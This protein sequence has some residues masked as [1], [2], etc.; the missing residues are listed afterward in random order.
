MAGE[1]TPEK[2]PHGRKCVYPLCDAHVRLIFIPAYPGLPDHAVAKRKQVEHDIVNEHLTGRCPM[3]NQYVGFTPFDPNPPDTQRLIDERLVVDGERARKEYIR[4]EIERERR[5]IR[6]DPPPAESR[7]V[8]PTGRG[9]VPIRIGREPDSEHQ[10]DWQLGGREDEESGH[11]S[12][13]PFQPV[14]SYVG[15]HSMTPGAGMLLGEARAHLSAAMNQ[16][17]ESVAAAEPTAGQ[18]SAAIASAQEALANSMAVAGVDE[19]PSLALA[20][21]NLNKAEAE[22]RAAQDRIEEG[23]QALIIAQE[24]LQTMIAHLSR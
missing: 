5:L 3:S 13:K 7:P 12:P 20:V 8:R 1:F 19:S 4:K 23:Q 9:G 16:A 21:V 18:L 11:I 10:E 24:K 14:P 15:G 6:G 17:G 2:Y 22:F